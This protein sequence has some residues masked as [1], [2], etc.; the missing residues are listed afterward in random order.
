M[1]LLERMRDLPMPGDG[2]LAHV[3]RAFG[4]RPFEIEA[5]VLAAL[6]ELDWQFGRL[7]AYAQ[8]HPSLTRPSAG[9]AMLL[10]GSDASVL[11]LCEGPLIRDGLVALDGDGPLASRT[12]RSTSRVAAR[13]AGRVDTVA[14]PDPS[15]LRTLVLDAE[16]R[17][18]ID[19]WVRSPRTLVLAGSPG[20]GRRTLARAACGTAGLRLVT[21]DVREPELARREAIWHDAAVMFVVD[22][23][24]IE[25]AAVWRALDGLA[26]PV[27]VV[28]RDSDLASTAAP[29]PPAVVRLELPPEVRRP[30]WSALATSADDAD[31]DSLAARFAFGP[32]RIAR[33]GDL[34]RGRH[35]APRGGARAR[36]REHGHARAAHAATVHAP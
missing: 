25:W 18:V 17:R 9:F 11:D 4:L 33:G 21:C 35:A 10:A 36:S 28:S 32:R 27:I 31:L 14:D 7:L 3:A 34:T 19:G 30:L 5:L 2:A 23:T 29:S 6:P 22:E 24:P 1:Q 16:S 8:D 13:L 20:S 12:L 15:L 26:R